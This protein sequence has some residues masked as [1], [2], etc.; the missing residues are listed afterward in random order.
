[1]EAFLVWVK[2]KSGKLYINGTQVHNHCPADAI[3][4]K[5][6]PADRGQEKD[7]KYRLRLRGD[8]MLVVDQNVK[9]RAI[10]EKTACSWTRK[11]RGREAKRFVDMLLRQDPNPENVHGIAVRGTQQKVLLGRWLL[12]RSRIS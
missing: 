9:S 4:H 7:G 2:L 6:A 3:K 10:P 11:K 5:M 1:M 12:C 8:N